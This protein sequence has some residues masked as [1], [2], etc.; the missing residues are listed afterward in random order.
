MGSNF[1]RYLLRAD[2]TANI[3]NFDKLTYAGNLDNLHDVENDAR[4][5]FV[6]GDIASRADLV[7]AVTTFQPEII[8]NFA[9]ETHVDRSILD[10]EAF[11]KTD[12][13]GTHN[14]LE[15]ARAPNIRMIQISTDEVYG[16][17]EQGECAE[18][19]A[20]A[21]RSPY[22][23]SKAA[24]DHLCHAYFVTYGTPVIVTHSCNFYGPYQYP[25]KLIP[26]F[27]T[28]LL[29]GKKVPVYGDGLQVRE[30][31]FTEDYCRALEAIAREGKAGET[32]NI[33][34]GFRISNLEVARKL[35]TLTQKDEAYL[36]YVKDRPGHDRRYA[37][38]HDK[39]SRELNWQPLV[40]FDEGL[41]RTVQWYQTHE[42]WWKKI[43][44]GEYL[45]YYKTWYE[46]HLQAAGQ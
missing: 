39:I 40:P 4:Y 22:A 6:R 43:K 20:F 42:G 21:P 14:L 12:V 26:L 32:Y 25:E 23:A 5:R 31:I 45:T 41:E 3:L 33:G 37:L 27:I 13:L 18:D 19:A 7:S 11:L 17:V 15:M 30:W 35:L 29:E 44:S 46:Q 8:I 38:S 36:E 1:I 2:P 34:T 24:A 10:P 9:A 28:N 16:H